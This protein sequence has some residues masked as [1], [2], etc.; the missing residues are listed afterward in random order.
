MKYL[1]L[2][3]V[4]LFLGLPGAM[5]FTDVTGSLDT[6]YGDIEYSITGDGV[7]TQAATVD[8][9]QSA[10]N[11]HI[12]VEGFSMVGSDGE[13][14]DAWIEAE[15]DAGDYAYS[16][17]YNYDGSVTLVDNLNLYGYITPN[18]A[19]TGLYVDEVKGSGLDFYAE[20]YNKE[21]SIEPY[22]STYLDW[23][24]NHDSDTPDYY[25][26][27]VWMTSQA[28]G[29]ADPSQFPVGQTNGFG[30]EGTYAMSNMEYGTFGIDGPE[31]ADDEWTLYQEAYS[32]DPYDDSYYLYATGADDQYF[33]YGKLSFKVNTPAMNYAD[34][35]LAYS[36]TDFAVT[37]A[38]TSVMDQ[39]VEGESYY[40][41]PDTAHDVYDDKTIEDKP[42][43]SFDNVFS[44][45]LAR[46]TPTKSI[47]GSVIFY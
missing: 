41:P 20:S 42:L 10:S 14:F 25:A 13:D 47:V 1:L 21:D 12:F 15:T 24:T 39:Y 22:Q 43:S 36:N 7:Q 17:L 26:K 11:A 29:S 40:Y 32:Y 46:A 19:W 23:Y 35:D 9:S 4:A 44:Y 33:S 8:Q 27:Q 18:L 38:G 34:A 16:E 28:G 30:G 3:V 37:G 6:S 2:L 5:A 45:G 31:S